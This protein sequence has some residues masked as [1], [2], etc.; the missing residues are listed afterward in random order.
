MRLFVLGPIEIRSAAG[1]AFVPNGGKQRLLLAS[2]VLHAPRAVPAERLIDVLWG[3]DIPADPPA[4]LRTQVSRLRA[5][6]GD[7]GADTLLRRGAPSGYSLELTPGDVDA[8]VFEELYRRASAATTPEE[9]LALT[10]EA[11]ARRAVR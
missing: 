3:D 5:L 9:A 6:L 10:E 1:R 11:P 4:A 2:L 8:G 7:A